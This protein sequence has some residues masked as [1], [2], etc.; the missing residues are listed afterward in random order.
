MGKIQMAVMVFLC[1]KRAAVK[2]FFNLNNVYGISVL[3]LS[4]FT[5]IYFFVLS[6]IISFLS[7]AINKRIDYI[8]SIGYLMIKTLFW[9]FNDKNIIKIIVVGFQSLFG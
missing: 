7:L 8:F 2:N 4:E 3:L 9:L 6:L 1:R 5:G